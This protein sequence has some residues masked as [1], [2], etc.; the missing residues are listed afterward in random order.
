MGRFPV[1]YWPRFVGDADDLEPAAAADRLPDQQLLR[2]A[3]PHRLQRVPGLRHPAGRSW[4][5]IWNV[6]ID[7]LSARTKDFPALGQRDRLVRQRPDPRPD[8]PLPPGARRRATSITHDYFGYFDIWGLKDSGNDV[9]GSGPAIVT[10]GPPGAGKAGIPAVGT[11]PRSRTIRGRFNFRHMQWFLARRRRAPVRGPPAPARGGLRLRPQL[12]RRVLQAALRDGHRPGDPGLPASTRRRTGPGPSGPR[13]TSRTATPRPSGCP[14]STTTAWATRSLEQLVHLLPALGRR[15]R[16]HPHRHR[17]QQ[18]EPLRLH[19]VRPDLE[20]ERGR[21]QP[22]RFYT[23]HELD[24]PLNFDN[25]LRVVPYVQGQV[26]GWTDQ[27]G[28][29]PST[30]S[31]RPMGRLG[32]RGRPRRDH[33]VEDL[34]RRRERAAQRPRPEPQDQLRRRLPRRLLE[35][36]RSTAIGVQDDLDDNTYEYVR[37]Y[38]AL[39][40]YAGGLLPP[41]YD[42]RHLILRRTLSPITGHDRHPGVDRDAP[43]RHPPAAPDQARARGPAADH[44][45][46]DARPRHDLLPQRLARQLRQAV[47]P[48]HVQLPVVHRRPDEHHLLRLVRVLQHHRQPADLQRQRRPATTTRSA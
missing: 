31:R 27:I 46:H 2:P 17:G 23:N 37:R 43:A 32:R 47:R 15:L 45:L 25:V 29:G 19:A 9:L 22:G 30:S 36:Q 44:R 35:R 41:Q 48:E 33:G 3:G 12:P 18:P 6:D 26:V 11:C 7:Y 20:H 34:P 42:P 13:P 28:G 16:Q 4:I 40:N 5:D 1:F 10:N 38:F 14:G 8:R 39:T 24:M 21:S